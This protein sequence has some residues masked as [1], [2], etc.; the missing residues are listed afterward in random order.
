MFLFN[1]LQRQSYSH[2]VQKLREVWG[3][4]VYGAFQVWGTSDTKCCTPLLQ[5]CITNISNRVLRRT[6]R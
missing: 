4:E 5:H 1:T 6:L 3:L 2:S